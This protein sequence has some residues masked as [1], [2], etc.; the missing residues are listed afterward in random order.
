MSI[1][2]NINDIME[3]NGPLS[4]RITTPVEVITEFQGTLP[5][6]LIEIWRQFGFGGWA[7]GLYRL[8]N[9]HD[10]D[11]LLSQV[12]HADKDFSHQDCYVIG[13]S[14]F[15]HLTVWSERHWLTDINLL[16][17]EVVSRRLIN[18]EKKKNPNTPIVAFL[19]DI[20]GK[21]GSLSALDDANK[22]LFARA[23]KRLGDLEPGECYGFFP[24][25]AM[26]GAPDLK[27]LKRTKALEHFTFLAQLQDF[28]LMDYL[29]RPIKTV[30]KIG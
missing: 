3:A 13:Y 24:A 20:N 9:P 16:R 10:F 11:G 5:D 15:G 1:Q 28:T 21:V 22:P 23:R 17:N 29:A 18:P 30:R 25:L 19:Y 8:C 6:I 27:N 26:G 14:A 2:D 7:N 4:Q 12:F